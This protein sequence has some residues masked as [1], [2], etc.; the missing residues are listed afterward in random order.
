MCGKIREKLDHNLHLC[1]IEG[2][3]KNRCPIAALATIK[4][5][6]RYCFTQQSL[7]YKNI[8]GFARFVNAPNNISTP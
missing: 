4:H 5:I 1:N 3:N 8:Q 2:M 6:E 7:E